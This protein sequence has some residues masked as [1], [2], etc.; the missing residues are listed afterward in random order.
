MPAVESVS[1]QFWSA[2]ASTITSAPD[3]F[4]ASTFFPS[5]ERS[6]PATPVEHRLLHLLVV[7]DVDE[8]EIAGPVFRAPQAEELA[9]VVHC[10]IVE[11]AALD[12]EQHRPL[13]EALDVDDERLL[14]LGVFVAALV[15][16]VLVLVLVLVRRRP[17][18]CLI[19]VLG[20]VAF[21]CVLIFRF[22]AVPVF[23]LG[24]PL[25]L[26]ALGDEGHST[27]AR[28]GTASRRSVLS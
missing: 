9:L 20:V 26:V 22:V 6:K 13:L 27:S 5:A 3:A 10:Q 19:L 7:R 23:A 2:A 17:C 4:A 16:G 11:P 21:A 24:V 8:L 28:S 15:L 25:L 1:S 18:P 14:V 12:G